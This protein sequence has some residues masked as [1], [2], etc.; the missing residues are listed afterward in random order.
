MRTDSIE[1]LVKTIIWR[2]FSMLFGTWI[3]Y[4]FTGD[5]VKS[6]IIVFVSGSSLTVLQWVFE[7]F[8]DR[9]IRESLRNVISRE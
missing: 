5:V 1:L 3:S 9:K 7:I 2:V 8:W 6:S 4:L